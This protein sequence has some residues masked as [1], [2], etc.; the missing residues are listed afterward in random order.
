MLN[1]LS[2]AERLLQWKDINANM[3]SEIAN[4]LLLEMKVSS[5]QYL[6]MLYWVYYHY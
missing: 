1:D 5:A 2:K 3:H 6:L 4:E